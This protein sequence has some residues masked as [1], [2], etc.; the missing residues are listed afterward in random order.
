MRNK[1]TNAR[2]IFLLETPPKTLVKATNA[3]IR[4]RRALPIRNAI[5]E[6]PIIRPFLPHPLHLGAAGL[7]IAEILLSD[8]RLFV[9]FDGVAIE[10]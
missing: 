9:D 6:M 4:I 1:H 10:G 5:K 2:E 7:E 8:P 3:I